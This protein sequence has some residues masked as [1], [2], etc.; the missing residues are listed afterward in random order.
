M[1]RSGRA[2]LKQA[3]ENL[4]PCVSASDGRQQHL[5]RS[6]KDASNWSPNE[7][8]FCSSS[9]KVKLP[10]K[11]PVQWKKKLIA[12]N[13]SWKVF[14]QICLFTNLYKCSLFTNSTEIIGNVNDTFWLLTMWIPFFSQ[15]VLKNENLH[16]YVNEPTRCSFYIY[17]FYNFHVRSTCFERSSRSSSEVN[18]SVLY[19][20]HSSV[21]SCERVNM[22]TIVQSCVIHYTTISSRWWMT[23]SFETRRVDMKIVE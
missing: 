1:I 21:Q 3:T 4:I 18:R 7:T 9:K 23:R 14:L 13:L 5:E 22:R 16:I 19:N 12:P 11:I 17:L 6:Q 15:F 8:L 20:T 2:A 10:A